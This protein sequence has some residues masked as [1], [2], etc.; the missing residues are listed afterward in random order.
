MYRGQQPSRPACDQ[1]STQDDQRARSCFLPIL[2][3][4]STAVTGNAFYSNTLLIV[5]DDLLSRYIW[6]KLSVAPR[7]GPVTHVPCLLPVAR[8]L[9]HFANTVRPATRTKH[10]AFRPF[11]AILPSVIDGS[12]SEIGPTSYISRRVSAAEHAIAIQL[13]R[14]N[15]IRIGNK[16]AVGASQCTARNDRA[17]IV[18]VVIVHQ[19]W[20][21]SSDH[22]VR[23]AQAGTSPGYLRHWPAP[24]RP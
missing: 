22:V 3:I 20:R 16:L 21:I 4:S 13:T 17:S 14:L 1:A 18:F 15:S 12:H 11:L 7:F 10:A 9:E 8:L 2:H 19:Y 6:R 5:I 23:V 24:S